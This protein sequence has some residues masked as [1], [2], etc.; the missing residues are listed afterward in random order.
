MNLYHVQTCD[1]WK[2][3]PFECR[4]GFI[5]R[6][7]D[8]QYSAQATK[9]AWDWYAMAWVDCVRAAEEASPEPPHD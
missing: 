6:M 4:A 2:V 5:E 8:C 7:R 3:A 1:T 9:D